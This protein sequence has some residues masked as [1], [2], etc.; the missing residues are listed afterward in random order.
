[1]QRK[2]G[3]YDVPDNE[4]SPTWQREDGLTVTKGD[5]DFWA[6]SKGNAVLREFGR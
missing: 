1:M 5:Y 6:D 3:T 4:L 2:D